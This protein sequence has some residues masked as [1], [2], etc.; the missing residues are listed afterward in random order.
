MVRIDGDEIHLNT[1]LMA[2][3]LVIKIICLLF[4]FK[5]KCTNNAIGFNDSVECLQTLLRFGQT[6]AS[7]AKPGPTALDILFGISFQK[8]CKHLMCHLCVYQTPLEWRL[9]VKEIAASRKW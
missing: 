8:C 6:F 1:Y 2:Y 4:G 9:F 3:D 7:K 5:T